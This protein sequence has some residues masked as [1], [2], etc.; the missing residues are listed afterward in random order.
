[1][2]A[3]M[4]AAICLAVAFAVLGAQAQSYTEVSA[5]TNPAIDAVDAS[6]HVEVDGQPHEPTPVDA[7]HEQPTPLHNTKRHPA[8]LWPAHADISTTDSD[9]KS[10]PPGVGM[11]SFRLRT[12]LGQSSAS[13]T[14]TSATND[15]S[16][17][18]HFRLL[19]A[20]PSHLFPLSA[21]PSSSPR[22]SVPSVS[23]PDETTG[24]S[25][26][27]GRAALG[28]DAI[29]SPKRDLSKYK[30]QTTGKRHQHHSHLP[31]TTT[32]TRSSFDSVATTGR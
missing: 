27:F 2:N 32:A 24:S 10:G 9:D 13:A 26:P 14:S 29:T 3:V 23:V 21:K 16:G 8:A 20:P 25:A 7:S 17:Q 12:R 28:I 31:V 15:D 18:D 22:T 4:S 5:K 30:D 1:M 19:K 6:V 11:S